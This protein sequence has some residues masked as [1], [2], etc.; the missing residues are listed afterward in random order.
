MASLINGSGLLQILQD[1][2]N[3]PVTY[4]APSDTASFYNLCTLLFL[5]HLLN[6]LP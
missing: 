2:T 3:T 4:A 5:L 6:D 1:K